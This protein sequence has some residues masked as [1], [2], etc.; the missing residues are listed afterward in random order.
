VT[1]CRNRQRRGAAVEGDEEAFV[2]RLASASHGRLQV[3]AARLPVLRPKGRR[4]RD[5]ADHPDAALGGPAGGAAR[6]AGQVLEGR[7]QLPEPSEG[8]RGV[9][10]EDLRQALRRAA[11]ELIVTI[12]AVLI[13]RFSNKN[14]AWCWLQLKRYWLSTRLLR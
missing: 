3:A 11:A 8:V 4:G 10:E 7:R 9:V 2:R 13:K 14:S 5:R 6:V 1:L 12:G